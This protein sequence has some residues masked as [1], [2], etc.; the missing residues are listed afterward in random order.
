MKKLF[1]LL[2]W[3]VS[4]QL[5]AQNYPITANISFSSNPDPSMANWGTGTS[6][7]TISAS[8]PSTS[9][10]KIDSRVME[11]KISV[12]IKKNG[13]KFC[14]TSSNSSAPSA[15]FNA[16]T[17]VWSGKNAVSL[18]GQECVLPPG[19]YEIC[20]QFFGYSLAVPAAPL[21]EEKCKSFIIP[22]KEQLVYQ[23][24]QLINPSNGTVFSQEDNKKPITFRWTP[25]VPK[26]QE[27]VTYRL[28][29]WQ[30]M[31]GQNGSQAMATNQP[32]ITKGY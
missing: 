12:I 9:I 26:P 15:G 20:V 17:K 25:V 22:A 7:L 6:A 18:I 8:T 13:V 19:E 11:S 5:V 28:K 1:T 23:S 16:T 3:M 4:M 10:G 21:S 14:G 29:V 32:V 31:Q 27:P 24:P 30:L 2:L